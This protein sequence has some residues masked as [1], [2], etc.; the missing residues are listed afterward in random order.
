MENTFES[1]LT[2]VS[3]GIGSTGLKR[4]PSTSRNSGAAPS[5]STARFMASIVACKMLMR[6]MVSVSTTATAQ[7]SAASRIAG[8]SAARSS[9]VSFFESSSRSRMP[10]G[11]KKRG[12]TTAA[13]TTGPAS[14]PRPASSMPQTR[15]S[16]SQSGASKPVVSMAKGR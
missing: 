4:L 14:G 16:V 6:S 11:L 3:N 8:A 5:D 1:P 15:D 13:A 10:V 7:L 9:A 12:K 2:T